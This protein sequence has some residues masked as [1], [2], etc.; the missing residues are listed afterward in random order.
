MGEF[1]FLTPEYNHSF[2]APVKNVIDWDST[3]WA[4]EPVAFVGYGGSGGTRAIARLRTVVPQPRAI[5]V[6]EP[7]LPPGRHRASD[8]RA[9]R[10][11]R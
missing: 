8:A 7:V 9:A 10:H 6:R 2:P 1:V 3:E 4:C 5:T 11:P